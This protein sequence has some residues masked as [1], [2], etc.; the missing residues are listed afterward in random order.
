LTRAK[1]GVRRCLV[2]AVIAFAGATSCG[3]GGGDQTSYL[4]TTPTAVTYIRWTEA[5]SE[6]SGLLTSAQLTGADSDRVS[7][8]EDDITGL[9]DEDRVTFTVGGDNIIG[10]FA[11]GRLAL[12]L[13]QRDSRFASTELHPGDAAAYEAALEN[14][15]RTAEANR[16]SAHERER[17]ER[18]AERRRQFE[19]QERER[20][21]REHR[22]QA[23]AENPVAG[24]VIGGRWSA[25]VEQFG[26]VYVGDGSARS[27][28]SSGDFS[29]CPPGSPTSAA[30]T[31]AEALG[32]PNVPDADE[33]LVTWII[34]RSCN[35]S[36]EPGEAAAV[37]ASVLPGDAERL[38]PETWESSSVAEVC[39]QQ[40]TITADV[41][42]TA[43]HLR[44]GHCLP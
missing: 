9:R 32:G 24:A 8:V 12:D 2:V 21:A 40:G 30:L 37:V 43:F 16:S 29:A 7:V 26:L 17:Q 33:G 3:L 11:N 38:S 41:S 19:E 31:V 1:R 39:G 5:G 34:G 35:G 23:I 28:T 14:L 10:R 22:L 44:L 15:E 13:P 4:A 27:D 42:D 6:L 18:V 36:F 25:W 20:A